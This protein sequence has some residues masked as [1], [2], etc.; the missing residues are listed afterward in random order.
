MADHRT[1]EILASVGSAGLL[2][3][4]RNGFVDMT[5]AV[6]SP[7]S[8]LKPFIY[9]LAFEAG[10][11]HPESLIE[12]RPTGFSGYVPVNFD[13]RYLGSVTIREALTRSLN[14]PAVLVLDAVGPSRLFSR[15]ERAGARLTLP[16]GAAAGLAIGLGGVG[17]S[18]R[19]LVSAYGA[20]ARGGSGLALRT[21]AGRMPDEGSRV[22]EPAAAWYVGDILRSTPPPA[23]GSAGQIAFKTGTSYGYRDAWAIGFDG[24]HV[25]GVWVGR[26]DAR[27]VPGLSG[28]E[29]AAPLLFEAF[30][31]LGARR[32][33]APP[34]PNGVLRAPGADL[35]PPLRRF[36]HPRKGP[37]ARDRAPEIAYPRDGVRVDLGLKGERA[38]APL[39][40]KLRNGEAPFTWLVNGRPVSR[41]SY[42]RSVRWVADGPGFVTIAVVDAAG[43]SD[44]VSIFVE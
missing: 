42:S 11:A 43:R 24:A 30:D 9:A 4:T 2:D 32:T 36:R 20:I 31:R 29:T 3:S 13:G 8:A 15:L 21:R 10:L 37:V 26:P 25:I 28:I 12:D 18:L 35:P 33:A 22:L 34:P 19:G 40:I 16:D 44:R 7:G 14:V 41:G 23:N 6:R 1:G 38:P 17:V 39:A 5:L 27:P